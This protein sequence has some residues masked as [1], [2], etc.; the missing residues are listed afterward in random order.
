MNQSQSDKMMTL[1]VAPDVRRALE[2]WAEQNLSTMTAEFNRCVW[3][4]VRRERGRAE[5]AAEVR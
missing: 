3:E 2:T 4:A 5:S 1:R